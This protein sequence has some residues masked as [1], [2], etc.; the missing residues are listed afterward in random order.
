MSKITETNPKGAGRKR[1]KFNEEDYMNIERWSGD[2][3]SEAQIATMLGCSLST[4]ARN[5]RTNDKFGTALKK[6][7]IRAIQAVANQ[8]F[9]NAMNGK[10]TSAIFFLKNRDPENWSDKAEVNHNLNLKEV[11]NIAKN[12]VIEGSVDYNKLSSQHVL[13]KDT[14]PED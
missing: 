6:G 5:K 2:G 11:L 1:I 14:L 3:L 8:V 9:V 13:T 10:E 4:I 7:K 12:R